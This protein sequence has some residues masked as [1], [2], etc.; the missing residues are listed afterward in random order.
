MS[1]A[2]INIGTTPGDHSGDPL[3]TAF[4]KINNNFQQIANGNISLTVNAPVQSVAGRTGNVVLTASDVIGSV[5]MGN[6][7]AALVAFSASYPTKSDL[8]SNIANLVDGA[9]SDLNTLNK[10]AMSLGNNASFNS[11]I[12]S[13]LTTIN[14]NIANLWTNAAVQESSLLGIISDIAGAN[15]AIAQNTIDIQTLFANAA[16]QTAAL[17]TLTS[18]AASQAGQLV[19]LTSN[20][21]TQDA[22]LTTLLANAATQDASLTNLLSNAATQGASLV[23]LLANAES[24]QST[25]T[26]LLA[27]T[28]SLQSEIAG[29]NAAIVTANTALKGYVDVQIAAVNQAWGANAESVQQQFTATNTAIIT[30]NTALK[31][32]VD[33]SNSSMKSYV[34]SADSVITIAWTANAALQDSKITGAN[35]AIVTANTAMGSYVDA[36]IATVTSNAATQQ[37]Q[38]TTLQSQV[39]T[40]SNVASYLPTFTGNISAGNVRAGGPISRHALVGNLAV[41]LLETTSAGTWLSVNGTTDTAYPALSTVH[42]INN[43][44]TRPTQLTIDHHNDIGNGT[45]MIRRFKGNMSAP[46][47]PSAGEVLGSYSARGYGTTGFALG[48]P[49][50]IGIVAGEAFT[51]SAQG[52]YVTVNTIR[53][54]VSSSVPHTKFDTSGNLVIVNGSPSTS[55]NTGALV[56]VGGAGIAGNV[57]LSGGVNANLVIT[58]NTGI[59]SPSYKFANGAPLSLPFDTAGATTFI[60][61]YSGIAHVGNIQF[62]DSVMTDMYGR[63]LRLNFPQ[64]IS[65]HQVY[66]E[67][68]LFANAAISSTSAY[69]GALQIPNGGAGIQGNVFC[70]IQPETRFQAGQ[71]GAYLPNVIGQF[72]SDVNG[73]SQVNMQNLH[74]GSLASSDYVVTADNGDDTQNFGDFGIANSQYAFPGYEA[75]MPND[76]YL[77]ANGGDLMLNAGSP[78][79]NIKFVVGGSDV[80]NVVGTW[81]NVALTSTTDILLAGNLVFDASPAGAISGASSIS[82]TNLTVLG[83][84]S[85]TPANA[86]NWNTTITSVYQA[87]DE[88]AQRLKTAGF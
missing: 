69:N 41:G 79:K 16:T 19:T 1:F 53:P 77:I 46:S 75:I 29:A 38:I 54:G 14:T 39:Y 31:S 70:A 4:S 59:V 85:Y 60:E 28:V 66:V 74:Q 55:I 44:A 22:S 40:N 73:Y 80:T 42:L 62:E 34:D 8:A 51:D 64:V 35:A 82:T 76:T 3:R 67:E 33:A 49:A 9:P 65:D 17:S 57:N 13:G 26:T 45:V 83:N 5:T 58:S 56:V 78:T 32:Y 61:T 27:N 24:Q 72:T 48:A 20:A 18:N 47:A 25:L 81:S 63:A 87:L 6:V 71:G 84:I 52:T 11:E 2:N 86:S 30:A 23:T 12:Q 37:G 7:N 15:A 43:D 10:I 50:G 36:Q 68:T 21:A 88:L